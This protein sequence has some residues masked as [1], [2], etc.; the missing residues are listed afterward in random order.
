MEIK[1][2]NASLMCTGE[3]G[4]TKEMR[5][6]GTEVYFPL[7]PNL[8]NFNQD[9]IRLTEEYNINLIFLQIQSEGI[10]D[11][12]ALKQCQE[13]GAIIFAFNGDK[14]EFLHQWHFD[15]APY[16]DC[17]L[18]S[19]MEDVLNMRERGFESQFL[20]LGVDPEKYKDWGKKHNSPKILFSGNNYGA[21]Y[22]PLSQLRIDAVTR[23]KQE[24]GHEFGVIGT[25][26]SDAIGEFNGNQ[27]RESEQYSS[28]LIALN[29]SHFNADRYSSDRL[30]RALASKCMVI[31]HHYLN[32]EDSYTP[33]EHLITFFDLDDLVNKCRYYLEKHEEREIIALAGQKWVLENYTFEKMALKIKDYFLLYE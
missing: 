11:P 24:F 22:F 2:I 3:N 32:I 9:L 14:R 27:V 29:I 16:V 4:F 17:F 20:E 28:A 15:I 30:V 31:S 1:L 12:N 33:G 13:L 5:K 7:L 6:I 26:W 8:T 23:L 21:S 18:F 19:N 10:L 25:G